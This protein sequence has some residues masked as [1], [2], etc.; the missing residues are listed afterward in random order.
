MLDIGLLLVSPI[1]NR[2]VVKVDNK[3]AGKCF[4]WRIHLPERDVCSIPSVRKIAPERKWQPASV[5]ASEI[6]HART[7]S[8]T[9]VHTHASAFWEV[10]GMKVRKEWFV[11]SGTLQ[12]CP[13]PS[14]PHSG[15]LETWLWMSPPTWRTLFCTW[16]VFLSQRISLWEPPS[17]VWSVVK[18]KQKQRSNRTVGKLMIRFPGGTSSSLE[19]H[20][21]L[22]QGKRQVELLRW[23]SSAPPKII[24]CFSGGC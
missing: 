24:S 2:A 11:S 1:I 12:S 18:E 21:C 4:W 7:R 23:E 22:H 15:I 17:V 20:P 8:R 14:P 13:W 16:P 10:S 3:L 19:E 5:L 9:H 6:T